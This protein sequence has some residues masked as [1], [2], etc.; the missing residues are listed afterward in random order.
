MP[1]GYKYLMATSSAWHAPVA[2]S[3]HSLWPRVLR[4]S[5][6]TSVDAIVGHVGQLCLAGFLPAGLVTGQRCLKRLQCTAAARLLVCTANPW[7]SLLLARMR[8]HIGSCTL[9]LVL[10]MACTHAAKL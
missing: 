6:Q 3:A 8:V 5:S 2:L 10:M 1:N 7:L 4:V 9:C